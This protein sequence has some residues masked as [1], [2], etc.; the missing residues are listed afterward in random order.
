MK[1]HATISSLIIDRSI[2]RSLAGNDGARPDPPP[3]LRHGPPASPKHLDYEPG[4]ACKR[5]ARS[6]D[7]ISAPLLH[8]VDGVKAMWL[9]QRQRNPH[10]AR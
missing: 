9:R 4:F 1:P 3:V 5:P 7:P 10:R 2:R 8:P 6:C